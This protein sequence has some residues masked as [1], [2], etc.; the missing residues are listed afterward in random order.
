MLYLK[1][2]L[3]SYL[4][5]L[6]PITM[7]YSRWQGYNITLIKSLNMWHYITNIYYLIIRKTLHTS[8]NYAYTTTNNF[9]S[10]VVDHEATKVLYMYSPS[11][12]MNSAPINLVPHSSSH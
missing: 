7:Y 3:S 4:N 2:I 9:F 11:N 1:R 12:S 10:N 5:D 6:T 8:T